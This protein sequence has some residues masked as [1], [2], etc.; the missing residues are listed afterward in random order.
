MLWC[1]LFELVWVDKRLPDLLKW[2]TSFLAWIVVWIAVFRALTDVV[3][4]LLAS[5]AD[6][7]LW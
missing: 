3:A 5:L 6:I 2:D 4:W 7:A 1:I